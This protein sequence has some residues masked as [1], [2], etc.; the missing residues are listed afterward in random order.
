MKSKLN[1]VWMAAAALVVASCSSAD[2]DWEELQNIVDNSGQNGSSQGS[3][4]STTLSSGEVATFTVAIDSTT[5]VTEQEAADADNE[6]YVENNSFDN[7]V[8][9]AYNGSSASITGEVSGV[10]LSTDGAHVTVNST[11]KGV[12]YILSG[13]A[14]D[15]SFKIYSEKKYEVTLNGVNIKNASGPAFNSQSGKRAYIVLA[16]GTYN[17]FSD[18]TAY[19]SSDEDQKGTLFSEG[20]LLFSGSGKLRIYANTKAGISSDDYILIRPYTNIYVKATAGNGIKANDEVKVN[21][22]ILN[23][24]V[25]ADAAKGISS[26]SLVSINGGRTTII[27]TGGG[28]YDS[29]EQDASACAGVKSDYAF[30]MNGGELYLKSTGDGGKGISSDGT[31]DINDG[32]LKIITEGGKY[33]YSSTIDSSPKGIKADGNVTISGGSVM[34]R[35]LKGEGS[36]GI[37][38]KAYMYLKGGA[39]EV[40]SYDDALNSKYDLSIQGGYLY[41]RASNNDGI[42]SN[43]NIYFEGGTSVIYGGATPEVPIDAAEGYNI[44]INGGTIAAFGQSIAQTAASGKQVSVVLGGSFSAGAT[45][46]LNSLLAVVPETAAS[47]VMFSSSNLSSGSV[48]T[49]YSGATVSGTDW[50]GLII[51]PT[52]SSQGTSAGS[53]TA[54]TTVGS[55]G[56][57]GDRPGGARR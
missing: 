28:Q 46:T 6:D 14:T 47:A 26:D 16:E 48:Y 45:Y 35:S 57:G 24:E 15:G 32:T 37:E 31:V 18:G 41:A 29:D 40:Y 30:V 22:G 56:M 34:V 50:H 20:E 53:A 12:N 4:G 5:T 8:Y 7:A 38:S 19:S 49:L 9:I 51:S 17:S 27:T 13:T 1:I 21:G 54:A 36:E 11:A 43:S 42:D 3:S 44:Y 39:T 23:I 2:T 52:V 25:S 10:T 55:S 33:S